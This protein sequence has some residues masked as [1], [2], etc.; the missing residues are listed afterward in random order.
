MNEVIREDYLKKLDDFR[1]DTRFVKIIT[2]VRRCGK[3]TLLHQFRDVLIESGVSAENIITINFESL[4]FE[5]I[6]DYRHLYD[7]IV[8]RIGDTRNYLL[9]DEIQRVDGWEKA[10]NSLMVDCDVDIYITGSNAYLLSSELSTYLSGRYVEIKIFPFSFKEYIKFYKFDDVET[11]L[12]NYIRFGGFP[13]I[14]PS[15][16]DEKNQS[17]LLGIYSTIVYKDI[18]QRNSIRDGALLENIVRFVLSNSGNQT[19]PLSIANYLNENSKTIDNYLKMLEESF[20]V[21]KCERYDLKGKKL[22]KT[23]AKY[24]AVDTGLKNALINFNDED[25]GRNIENIVYLELCRR[26]YN[27]SVGKYGDY[28]VDFTAKKGSEIKYYQVTTSMLP[29]DVKNRELRSLNSLKD[30]YE[31]I[32][33]SLDKIR[34]NSYDGIRSQYLIDFLLE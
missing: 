33:I 32:I 24:Y 21:Y 22:L 15:D 6:L 13:L 19:T 10:I 4:N 31:K 9:L 34:Q 1:D 7:Y 11:A 30:N 14:D 18:I 28:E 2:G 23:A 3:S 29:E 17:I 16:S 25:L 20:I 27:V 5:D 8:G 26:G 12:N